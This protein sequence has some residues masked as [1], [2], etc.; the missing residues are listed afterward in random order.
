MKIWT[1][2]ENSAI[3][4]VRMEKDYIYKYFFLPIIWSLKTPASL[5]Q[6][7]TILVQINIEFNSR[8]QID[9]KLQLEAKCFYNAI[10]FF[11]DQFAADC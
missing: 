2:T 5:S 7:V 6:A 10:R 11:I 8:L 3:Q 9:F 4:N 1:I